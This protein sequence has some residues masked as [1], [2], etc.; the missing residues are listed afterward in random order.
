MQQALGTN[1][2]KIDAAAHASPTAE[3]GGGPN[4]LVA[5][6]LGRL[7]EIVRCTAL[8]TARTDYHRAFR[9]H[10]PVEPFLHLPSGVALCDHPDIHL[11]VR[12]DSKSVG[13][14]GSC[15]VTAIPCSTSLSI[16]QFNVS[17]LPVF[18]RP[19]NAITVLM[20]KFCF[21]ASLSPPSG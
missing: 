4:R 19:C 6:G 18:D 17:V 10:A 5:V 1:L 12:A 14:S 13:S 3:I 15:S 11:S 7:I 20:T 21:S 9:R 8:R 2:V 16:S